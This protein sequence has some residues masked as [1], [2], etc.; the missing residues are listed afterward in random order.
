MQWVEK[1]SLENIRRLLE[2]SEQERH[3]EVLLT[4]KNLAD[5]RWSPGPYNLP[6]IPRSLPSEI[7]GGEHFVTTDL[8]D[9]LAGRAPSPRDPKAD[10]LSREQA[11]RASPIPSTSNSGGSSSALPVPGL[12]VGSVCPAGLPLPRKRIDPTPR[13]LTIKKKNRTTQG[14]SARGAQVEDFIPWVH[15]D[16]SRPSLSEEEEEEEEEMTRLLDRYAA[17][18]RKRQEEAERE[19]ERA[20]GSVRPPMDGGSKIQRIMIPASPEM[21]SSDQLGSE[22]IAREDLREEAPITPALQVV[23]PSERPESHPGAARL[24]LTGRKKSL[25]PDRI[26]LNSYLP[27]RGPAPV[28]EEVAVPGPD[29]IKSILHHWKPFNRGE[30]AADRLDDLYPR[31]LQLPVRARE[32]GQ[33]EEHS[34]VVLVG[35]VKEDIYQIV[36]DGMQIRNWNF[37]QKAELVK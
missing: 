8:L 11:L 3:C 28:M 21:R 16:P 2:V 22:D 36:E 5:V 23:H 30:S 6:I 25:L 20:E 34:V 15:S 7:V 35:T 9:L 26:L 27:S 14:K 32:A 37:A 33:G 29:D 17:R 1:V 12:E 18:K 10:A 13:V 24:V 4:L 31:M 19:A